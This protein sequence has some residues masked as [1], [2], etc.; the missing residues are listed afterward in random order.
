MKFGVHVPVILAHDEMP[1]LRDFV[2]YGIA[3]ERLGYSTVATSDHIVART[4][5][6]DGPSILAAIGGATEQIELMTAVLLPVVRHPAV[7]AQTFGSLDRMTNGRV[8]L[9]VSA[10]AHHGD[11][12]LLEIPWSERWAR[13]DESI[14]VMRTLWTE[15]QPHFS[16]R[17]YRVDG[18][19]P[20]PLPTR[21]GPP[22]WVGSWGSRVG[23]RRVAR[24]GDGWI[25]SG[26]NIT[27]ERFKAA[28]QTIAVE[29]AKL[30]KEPE[31]FGNAL[32]SVFVYISDD[33]AEPRRIARDILGPALG[34][35]PHELL[36]LAIMGTPEACAERLAQYAEA[37]VQRLL[38]WPAAEPREQ[39][40]R[41]SRQVIPLLANRAN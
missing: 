39:I 36:R 22:I 27:P 26:F 15:P 32:A 19:G 4:G 12:D 30:G 35:D 5:W 29:R 8:I 10:G 16:G 40:E 21:G 1:P 23:L 38:I 6:L 34:R 31:P 28:W 17:F 13:L 25:A 33:P 24:L 9:G 14:E 18:V 7:V 37:G 11:F 20:K 2:D 3:A 41:F